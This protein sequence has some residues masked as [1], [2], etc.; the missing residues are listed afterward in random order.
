MQTHVRCLVLFS[1]YRDSVWLMHLSYTLE[2]M[3][4]VQRVAVM[5]GTPHNKALL[6]DAGLLTAEGEAGGANDL[7]VCVQ[8]DTPAIAAEALQQATA[9]MTPQQGA[10]ATARTAAPRTLETALRRLPEANL[11]CISVPGEYAVHEARKALQHGLHVFLFSA[12]VDLAAEIALKN[13]AAEQGLLVM[14]PDCGTA[15]LHGIPLGFANQIPRGPVGLIAASGTGLQQ[16]SCLLAGQGVGVSQAIGVGGRDVHER[17]GGHSMRAALRTLAQDADTRVL[18]LIAKPPAPRVA[19]QLTREA[20]QMGKPCVLAFVGEHALTAESA[21][22]YPATTLE[23]AALLA[24]ALVHGTPAWS[25]SVALPAS[26]ATEAQA[27]STALQ[28]GQRLLHALYC[29]G[30]L[31]HEAL[32]LLRRALGRVGSNLDD[33]LGAAPQ[34]AHMVLDLGAEEFTQGRPHPMIDPSARRPYLLEAAANPAVAVVLVDVMLGWGAHPD[35]AGLLA[36]AWREAQAVASAAGRTLVGIA[37]VCGALDDP[38]D[39]AQQCQLLREHGLLLADSNA[40][41]VRLASAVLGVHAPDSTAQGAGLESPAPGTAAFPQ[42]PYPP[43]GLPSRLP[44][45][46]RTGPRVVNLGLEL[47]A[48]QLAAH[49]TPVVHVDWR[50]PAGGDARLA[51]LLARLQ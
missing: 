24:R 49:G 32:G 35:P 28:P 40:Q 27:A 7:L 16:V 44:E 22:V 41:A 46:L 25:A 33:T 18:V 51:S 4:G 29:G 37:H 8:A 3:P 45:L 10:G 50:P 43:V 9:R 42:E 38:Q 30:T 5:M 26:L 36:A 47:F 6:Q 2:S 12:H 19:A 1:M 31:A 34:P 11:A 20:A 13:L 48:T 21:G 14:G 23:E 15:I 39:F 17:I